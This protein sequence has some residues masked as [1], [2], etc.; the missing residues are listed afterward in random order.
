MSDYNPSLYNYSNEMAIAIQ[1]DFRNSICM[2]NKQGGFLDRDLLYPNISDTNII[3]EIERF[4]PILAKNRSRDTIIE[5]LQKLKGQIVLFQYPDSSSWATRY[6]LE[7]LEIDEIDLDENRVIFKIPQGDKRTTYEKYG[8]PL[9]NY[10]TFQ[11]LIYLDSYQIWLPPSMYLKAFDLYPGVKIQK[12]EF[13]LQYKFNEKTITDCC[14]GD[15]L[16]TCPLYNSEVD[17]VKT[18]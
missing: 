13:F 12:D 11:D 16:F 9:R 6:H 14:L 2:Y 7:F 1:S 18:P 10:T 8:G 5:Y 3:E 17:F 15:D 4:I